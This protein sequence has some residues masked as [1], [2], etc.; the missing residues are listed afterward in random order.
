MVFVAFISS[1]LGGV[2][3]IYRLLKPEFEKQNKRLL[4]S[5]TAIYGKIDTVKEKLDNSITE[6]DN[7]VIEIERDFRNELHELKT[8]MAIN[9]EKDRSRQE[10]MITHLEAIRDEQSDQKE[11]MKQWQKNIENFYHLNPE[12]VKPDAPKK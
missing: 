8:E 2:I 12:L 3:T 11:Q 7:K 9:A 5:E 6:V 1:I 4:N 10:I